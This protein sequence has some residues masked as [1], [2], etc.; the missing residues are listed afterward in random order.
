MSETLDAREGRVVRFHYRIL[1]VD[2]NV[3]E[4][5]RTGDPLAILLGY[6][7]VLRSIEE[8]LTGRQSGERFQV[9]LPPEQAYGQ[10]REGATQRVP[11]KHFRNP[12]RLKT[13][14][15]TQLSTERGTRPVTV[16]KVG[17]KVVD[18]DLNHPQAG[19]TLTF[20]L[21]VME[22]RDA[23]PEEIAHRHVHGP[24]GHDH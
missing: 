18:V 16:L 10:R 21:E 12:G 19:K 17:A 15:I 4:S 23:T 24:G 9:T 13:G 3:V 8:A 11:K 20:D 5:S 14:M 1:D 6:G 7:V 2:G 22:V